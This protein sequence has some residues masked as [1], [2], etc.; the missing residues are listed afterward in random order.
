MSNFLPKSKT[1][2]RHNKIKTKK[3]VGDCRFFLKF[4]KNIYLKHIKNI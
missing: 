1:F 2:F 4:Y 3:G